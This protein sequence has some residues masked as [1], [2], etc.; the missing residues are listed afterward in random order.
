MK[1]FRVIS[2]ALESEL[3]GG[4]RGVANK[5]RLQMVRVATNK[6]MLCSLCVYLQ[7]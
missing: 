6:V 1:S 4:G 3:T 5:N 2:F 7:R